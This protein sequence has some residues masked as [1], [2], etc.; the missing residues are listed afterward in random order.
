MISVLI[1]ED[2]PMLADIHK[3]FI[4]KVNGFKVVDIASDGMIALNILKNNLID[5][6]ILDVYL[7]QLDGLALIQEMRKLSIRSDVILVT[8]AKDVDQ[9]ETALKF[10]AFDYLVKPFEFQRLKKSLNNYLER[11]ETLEALNVIEQSGIDRIFNRDDTSKYNDLPKGF[12]IMT[13]ERVRNVVK[14]LAIQYIDIEIIAY[15]IDMSKVTA[16]RYL[17]YLEKNGEIEIKMSYGN[18]GRPSY[19]YRFKV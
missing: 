6:V 11:T 10:G 18:R 1:V 14:E 12:H 9:I 16:R 8:A 3:K 2:D 13:L 17:D 15:E 7:P 19:K 4:S 5:L